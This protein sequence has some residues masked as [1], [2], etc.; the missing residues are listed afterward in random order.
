M[1]TEFNAVEED[2]SQTMQN[3]ILTSEQNILINLVKNQNSV[4]QMAVMSQLNF[5]NIAIKTTDSK[6]IN[7][8]MDF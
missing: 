5:N 7:C 8:I 3:V 4:F 1:M 6:V 2:Y